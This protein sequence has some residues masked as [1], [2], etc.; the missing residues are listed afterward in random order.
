MSGDPS[1]RFEFRDEDCPGPTEPLA[2]D[3]FLR[4]LYPGASW[5]AVRRLIHGGKVQV[6][7]SAQ[8]NREALVTAGDRV[9]VRLN[10]PRR[11]RA[12]LVGMLVHVDSQVVVA[13][14]P[15]GI[16]TVPYDESEPDT[17]VSRVRLAL[18]RRARTPRASLEIVHRIDKETSGLVVFARTPGAQRHLKDQFREHRA[19]REYLG[20]AHGQLE[21]CSYRSR[22]VRDR[23]DGLRGSTTHSALGRSA[24][25]HVFVLETFAR[26]TL[27]RCVLETGRTHQIRIH[28][29]EAG[30]PLLG[31]RVYGRRAP[32]SPLR[33][34]R[35]MLHARTLGFEHPTSGEQLKFEQ[36]PP[37]E[38]ADF[39]ARLRR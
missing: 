9:V 32:S 16:S 10:A 11:E 24:V 29:A 12:H 23:G 7:G 35:L 25:T 3:R 26:A 5:N 18:Q 6:N 37:S 15:A 34:P 8:L 19:S 39:L 13:R 4:Q 31:E 33:A 36:P 21:P 38:M 14:K 22:L 27:L 20:I 28:L 30:H 17:L 1:T 2:I